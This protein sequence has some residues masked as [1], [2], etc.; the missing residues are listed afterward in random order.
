MRT[1]LFTGGRNMFK[2]NWHSEESRAKNDGHTWAEYIPYTNVLWIKYLF[3]WLHG[4]YQKSI[5]P[6]KDYGFYSIPGISDLRHKFDLRTRQGF[7]SAADLLIFALDQGW[8]TNDQI[9]ESGVDTT[10]LS[11]YTILRE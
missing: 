6:K 3:G 1:H 11:N 8:I 9:D 7:E 2:R 4:H 10:I 5:L